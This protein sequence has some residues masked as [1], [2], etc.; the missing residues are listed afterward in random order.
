MFRTTPVEVLLRESP[1]MNFFDVLKRK[2]HLFLIKKYTG[3]DTHPTKRL[4]KHNLLHPE[5]RH[6]SPTH[7]LLDGQM[8]PEYNLNCIETIKHHMINP[9]DNFKINVKNFNIKKEEAKLVVEDQINKISSQN[10]H[11][12]FTDGSR[13]PET[14]TAAAAI[15]NR[16]TKA[17]CCIGDKDEA[18]SFEAEVMAIK[19]GINIII[20]KIYNTQDTFQYSSKKLNFFIDNQATI[21]SIAN[22]PK[23]TSNQI[24]FHEIYTKIQLLMEIFDY[25]ISLFWCPAHVDI[26]ENEMV[27]A[28]AKEATEGNLLWA[29]DRQRTLANIQQIARKK[30]KFDQKKK[31]II[32]N[33]IKLVTFPSKIFKTP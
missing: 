26:T 4:I 2:N 32:R 28:L 24:V 19:L 10:E 18:S 12:I 9:W 33:K 31:P 13:I 15:V 27:D 7:S 17:A 3:P 16:T 11:L 6:P 30:F 5:S 25:S 21:L 29:H 8:I 20:N 23:P 22:R 14:R 1:L